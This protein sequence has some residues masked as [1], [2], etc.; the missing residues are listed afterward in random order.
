MKNLVRKS[1]VYEV[2][3]LSDVH[4]LKADEFN[5]SDYFVDLL[6]IVLF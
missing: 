3:G 4:L 6:H 1:P 5:S 2:H